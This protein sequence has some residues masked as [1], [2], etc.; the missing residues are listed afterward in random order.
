VIVA[1]SID[2]SARIA[3]AIDA[4]AT[5]FTVGTAALDGI[6]PGPQSLEG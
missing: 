2:R 1:G 6:F 5:G 3:E 4:G